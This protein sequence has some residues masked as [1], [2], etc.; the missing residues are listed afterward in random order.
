MTCADRE[1][2]DRLTTSPLRRVSSYTHRDVIQETVEDAT[3]FLVRRHP[4]FRLSD[5]LLR[6]RRHRGVG[7][8]RVAASLSQL[9][10]I[11]GFCYCGTP[12]CVLPLSCG[13]KLSPS[14]L[15]LGQWSRDVFGFGFCV[16]RKCENRIGRANEGR[17][18][19]SG[20]AAVW[21]PPKMISAC[22]TTLLSSISKQKYFLPKKW[23]IW[24]NVQVSVLS[25][26][27]A[28]I[29]QYFHSVRRTYFWNNCTTRGNLRRRSL[30]R[31]DFEKLNS[32][33]K[34][35]KKCVSMAAR[36]EKEMGHLLVGSWV[37]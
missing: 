35:R 2:D 10:R 4:A 33:F 34:K 23:S 29:S 7:V 36:D 27:L 3:C 26:E 8:A 16:L 6:R 32:D 17:F 12:V 5:N 20:T 24:Q 21:T 9:C 22:F 14:R 31:D 18:L 19:T 28:S 1:A 11:I 13:Q 30:G 37:S 25:S 15:R